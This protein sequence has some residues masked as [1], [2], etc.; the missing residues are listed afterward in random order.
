MTDK[1]IYKAR[2]EGFRLI[3]EN[4]QLVS[5]TNFL[6]FMSYVKEIVEQYKPSRE[7][8]EERIKEKCEDRVKLVQLFRK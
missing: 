5:D 7:A 1:E 6:E 2:A 4:H 3:E 8:I